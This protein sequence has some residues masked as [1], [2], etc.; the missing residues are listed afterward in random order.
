MLSSF[1]HPDWNLDYVRQTLDFDGVLNLI[2]EQLGKVESGTTPG[3]PAVVFSRMSMKIGCIQRYIAGKGALYH[4]QGHQDI[5]DPEIART[6]VEF[7]D[8]LDEAW[9][10]DI[11]GP[12][13]YQPHTN[14][15]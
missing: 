14:M 7:S 8:F 9:L 12:F 6:G 2:V 13:E 1:E 5:L 10:R 3:E 4:S 15:V 11:L